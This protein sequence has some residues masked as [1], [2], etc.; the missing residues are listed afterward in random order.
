MQKDTF[1]FM[2]VAKES[3]AP[4]KEVDPVEF[5]LIISAQYAAFLSLSAMISPV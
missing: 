3:G 5:H 1:Y 4:I 2:D